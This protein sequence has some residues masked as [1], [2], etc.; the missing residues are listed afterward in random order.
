MRWGFPLHVRWGHQC[1]LSSAGEYDGRFAL[2]F[3][4]LIFFF[5]RL[6]PVRYPTKD[7]AKMIHHA[8]FGYV[9]LRLEREHSM[10]ICIRNG[11]ASWRKRRMGML[12]VEVPLYAM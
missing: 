4:S 9:S 6:F 8:V 10:V 5:L 11:T 12:A 3:D 1:P 2:G 7:F